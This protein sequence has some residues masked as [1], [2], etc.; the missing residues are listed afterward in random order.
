MQEVW[1]P[2]TYVGAGSGLYSDITARRERRCGVRN[3]YQ[4]ILE[5][6]RP[7][8]S[9]AAE[10]TIFLKDRARVNLIAP[11]YARARGADR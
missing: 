3:G 11:T 1:L 8:E 5:G 10:G 7:S 9:A 2:T 4:Q 6:L